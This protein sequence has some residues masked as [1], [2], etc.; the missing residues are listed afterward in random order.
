MNIFEILKGKEGDADYA[1]KGVIVQGITGAYGSLHTRNMIA[2]GTNVVAGGSRRARG[3]S[4]L[5]AS[6]YMTP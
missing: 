4:P 1:K 6:Q 5:T 3:A 2:Y